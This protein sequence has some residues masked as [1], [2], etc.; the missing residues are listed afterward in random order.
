MWQSCFLIKWNDSQTIAVIQIFVLA[1]IPLTVIAWS[2]SSVVCQMFSRWAKS[3][4]CHDNETVIIDSFVSTL[5]LHAQFTQHHFDYYLH[6]FSKIMPL[7]QVM[8][9][10]EF[11][12]IQWLIYG[13][14]IGSTE[15]QCLPSYL[16]CPVS[17][18]ALRISP[19]RHT[20]GKL[21]C[22]QVWIKSRTTAVVLI[23]CN[24]TWLIFS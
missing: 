13:V 6:V 16:I 9:K 1:A 10:L 11:S 19:H 18:R 15:K 12:R 2:M 8:P 20:G 22:V 21:I 23:E 3:I 14:Y 7:L 4:H 24:L 17:E 5:K